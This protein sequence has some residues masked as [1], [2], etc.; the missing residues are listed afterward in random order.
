M[1]TESQIFIILF[2]ALINAFL[3]LRFGNNLYNY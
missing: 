3:A 2:I 1:I